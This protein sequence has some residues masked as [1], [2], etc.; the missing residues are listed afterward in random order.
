MVVNSLVLILT[1]A[2]FVFNRP[3]S[4]SL[5]KQNIEKNVIKSTEEFTRDMMLMCVNA[6]MYNN[7][8][9][10]VYSMAQEMYDEVMRAIEVYTCLFTC[11]FT[12][13]PVYRTVC[14]SARTCIRSLLYVSIRLYL[15]P[16]TLVCVYLLTSVHVCSCCVFLLFVCPLMSVS[17]H[18]CLSLSVNICPL[19][20][21]LRLWPLLCVFRSLCNMTVR[22]RLSM[23]TC[24]C[25]FHH[26]CLSVLVAVSLFFCI[27]YTILIT[28]HVICGMKL[29]A[30]KLVIVRGGT[31]SST[32][33]Q[34]SF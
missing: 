10:D 14:L 23:F 32:Q 16:P 6:I 29:V 8:E 28:L 7:H 17:V 22:A 9:Y 18:L 27:T 33:V 21:S 25:F 26:A 30:Y 11:L 3:M 19:L 4:L 5:I 12:C 31:V 13:L 1:C 2:I 24:C 15:C 34:I 20:I